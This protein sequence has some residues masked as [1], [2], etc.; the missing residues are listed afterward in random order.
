MSNIAILIPGELRFRD[1]LH[2]TNF[3][4]NIEGFDIF[5]STYPKYDFLAKKISSNCIFSEIKLPL[6]N[7]YQ[8]YHLDNIIKT[9]E[10]QLLQYDI[11]VKIR[12]D[13]EYSN[14]KLDDLVVDNDTIYAQTDQL[15]YGKPN[16]ITYTYG[17]MY[18][19]VI[20]YY[21]KKSKDYYLP[22]NY[23]NLLNSD[24]NT[25]VKI[26]WLRIP[27]LVYSTNFHQL[28]KNIELNKDVFLSSTNIETLEMLDGQNTDWDFSSERCF[29]IHTINK[30]LIGKSELFGELMTNRHNFNWGT[31]K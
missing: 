2:F 30:G 15:F 7:M 26:N 16:H 18:I 29:L 5:I 17:D 27:K 14:F 19:N 8:W 25:N 11:L 22:I 21:F 20:N 31:I 9:W 23:Y 6:P 13:L 4:K 1:E 12:T 3:L 10:T 24:P 28:Q